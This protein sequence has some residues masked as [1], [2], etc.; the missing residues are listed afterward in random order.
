MPMAICVA[1]PNALCSACDHNGRNAQSTEGKELQS[2]FNFVW[3][4]ALM[5]RWSTTIRRFLENEGALLYPV[6]F[7]FFE[8][9]DISPN[10]FAGGL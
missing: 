5:I 4:I 9:G 8:T 7:H 6:L 2:P 1:I 3:R 10:T